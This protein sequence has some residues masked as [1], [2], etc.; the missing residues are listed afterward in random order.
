[1][2]SGR[3]LGHTGGT[4]DKLES[5][6]G[7]RTRLRLEEFQ[8]VVQDVGAGMCGQ[9]DDLAPADRILYSLRDATATVESIPL[10]TASILSKKLAEGVASLVFDVKCGRGAFM[11]SERAARELA[12]SLSKVSRGAGV[13][14]VSVITAMDHLLGMTAGNAL[15]VEEALEIL[16][17]RG[18]GDVAS[19]SVILAAEMLCA[20]SGDAVGRGAA[21]E[22]CA[23]ALS[24]GHALKRFEALIEAQGGDLEAFERRPPA[25]V[26]LEAVS[27]GSGIFSGIDAFVLGEAVRKMGAGRIR[28]DDSVDH[29]AGWEQIARHGEA[30]KAG[31]PLGVLHARDRESARTAAC[32]IERAVMLDEPEGPLVIGVI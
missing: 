7:F 13:R 30:V 1:M 16:S 20:A 12:E 3:A 23:R 22:I 31:E 29:S 11:K 8:T 17:G 25:P 32:A 10:I 27:P 15:E 24:D 21:R 26:R 6:P 28:T 5:I 18:P 9:T 4:L 2:I 19:L 14:T